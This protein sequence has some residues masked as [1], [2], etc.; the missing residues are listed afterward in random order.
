M[1]KLFFLIFNAFSF[2]IN[3]KKVQIV[4][5][6]YNLTHSILIIWVGKTRYD[7]LNFHTSLS[8]QFHSVFIKS[9]LL[10][11][12]NNFPLSSSLAVCRYQR[13]PL[14]E[15][16]FLWMLVLWC[17]DDTTHIYTMVVNLSGELF[18]TLYDV[19]YNSTIRDNL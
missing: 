4:N 5:F 9:R 16:I 13:Y 19:T 2:N 12:E 1:L 8:Q 7:N 15:C 10:F 6:L 3:I 18:Q 14:I 17:L 11:R